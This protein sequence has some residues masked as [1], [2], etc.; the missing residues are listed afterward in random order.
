[1]AAARALRVGGARDEGPAHDAHGGALQRHPAQRR[2][3]PRAGGSDHA[4]LRRA[5]RPGGPGAHGDHR[6]PPAPRRRQ[7]RGALDDGRRLPG[8]GARAPRARRPRDLRPRARE[9]GPARHARR[10]PPPPL[11]RRRRRGVVR[12]GRLRD[13]RAVPRGRAGLPRGG[14]LGRAA[15]RLSRDARGRALHRGAGARL[16]RGEPHAP[17]RVLDRAARHRPG[18]GP[19]PGALHAGGGRSLLLGRGEDARGGGRLRGGEALPRDADTRRRHRRAGPAARDDGRERAVG[20]LPAPA[21]LSRLARRA[22]PGRALRAADGAARRAREGAPRSPP[23]PPRPARPR[24]LAL[25]R[26]ARPRGRVAAAARPGRGARAAHRARPRLARG[27]AAPHRGARL[28][29]GLDAGRAPAPARREG[30]QLRPRPGSACR[31]GC[32]QG[33]PRRLPGRPPP[34]RQLERALVDARAGDGPEPHHARGAGR[35]PLRRHLARHEPAG[36]GR[37]GQA[38][39]HAREQVGDARRGDHRRGRELPLARAG[40]GPRAPDLP[41]GAPPRGGE[42]RRRPRPRPAARARR[43]RRQPLVGDARDLAPVGLRAARGAHAPARGP[44]PH[45]HRAARLPPRRDGAREGLPAP[46]RAGDA[47]AAQLRGYRRDSGT[48]RADLEAARHA[49]ARRE[50]LRG[51]LR[52]EPADGRLLRA[53]GGREEEALRQRHLPDRRL[54]HPDLRGGAARAGQGAA[55]RGVPGGAHLH[56]L[57]RRQGRGPARRVAGHAVP[58]HLV[59]EA[60]RGLRVLLGRALLGREA[61]RVL[62]QAREGRHHRRE[63][64]RTALPRPRRRADRAAAHLRGR[65]DGD[66]PRRPDRHQHEARRRAP[67]LRPRAQGAAL[68]RARDR[69]RARG[70][71]GRPGWQLAEGHRGEG[72]AA[73][74]PVALA[75]PRQR[76]L[77]RRGPLRDRRGRREGLRDDRHERRGADDPPPAARPRGRLRRRARGP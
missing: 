33:A 47:L 38:R 22:G 56:L 34:P 57:R 65:G 52:D 64:R 59:A 74:P 5:D 41:P 73:E 3:R 72:A 1:M 24:L 76:L 19:E 50:L 37:V 51:L 16:P 54:P 70:D 66:R 27:A 10:R 17:A 42:R 43:L 55:R 21:E 40:L 48:R 20:L 32:R 23:A 2:A 58:V 71:R 6:A 14:G 31:A 18:R 30:G 68:P 67:A 9:P 13:R 44:L 45:L 75:P 12:R 26:A 39:G 77:E 4:H 8:E 36:R 28:A 63:R 15:P 46:P 62:R 29:A 53:P 49:H 7:R 61:L 25:S 69:G 35:R 60:A 11:A